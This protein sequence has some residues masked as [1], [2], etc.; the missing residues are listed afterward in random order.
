MFFPKVEEIFR[1]IERNV[2]T[3]AAAYQ[4]LRF[5]EYLVYQPFIL[6]GL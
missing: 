1:C 3:R 5:I 4:S 6:T 2:Y